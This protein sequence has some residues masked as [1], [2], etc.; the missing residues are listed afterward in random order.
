MAGRGRLAAR[1]LVPHKRVV[2]L[3][4]MNGWIPAADPLHFDKPV[5]GVGLGLTF[6]KTMAAADRSARVGLVPCAR[7]GTS[8]TWWQKDAAAHPL[9]GSIYQDTLHRMKIA[10]RAGT[11][12]GVL[13][14]QGESDMAR[15]ERYEEL[16]V[17]FI[18]DLRRDLEAPETP[19]VVGLLGMWREQDPKQA[20]GAKRINA[21]LRGLPGEVNHCAVVDSEGLVNKPDD[22]GHFDAPSLREFGRRYAEAVRKLQADQ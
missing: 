3:G 7:G 2:A 22:V 21:I 17:R 20:E 11:L 8:V 15:P 19:F 1:D 16:L 13:W 12:K 18:A 14:H 4:K 10:R 9:F 5:A 6:G